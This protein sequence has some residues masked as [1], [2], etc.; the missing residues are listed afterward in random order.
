[1]NLAPLWGAIDLTAP[2]FLVLRV[3]AA[4]GGAVVGWFAAGP[5]TRVLYYGAFHRKTPGWVTPWFRLGG[6]ALVGL[7]IFYL[8]PLGGGS[9][10]GWG[11]GAGGNP[12]LGA[13]DGSGKTKEQTIAGS[14]KSI[15]GKAKIALEA[16]QIEL[17][18]GA[19]YMGDGRYYLIQRRPPAETLEEVEEYFKKNKERLEEYV[20]IILTPE[21]VAAQ[22]GAV[23]RLNTIIEKYG[24]I[25]VIKNVNPEPEKSK[26]S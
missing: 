8:L 14:D 22:H 16:L 11:P 23:L 20:T 18:G 4:V 9:G 19:R 1:V 10:F 25:P 5:V 26:K 12:G 2:I 17:L 24:R 13:G 21:S 6:A 7:L 15:S 3:A